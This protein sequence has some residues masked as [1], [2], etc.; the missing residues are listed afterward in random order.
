[1]DEKLVDIAFKQLA[2]LQAKGLKPREWI[3]GGDPWRRILADK[4]LSLDFSYVCIDPARPARAD[5]HIMGL[6]VVLTVEDHELMLV[7]QL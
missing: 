4:T 6:P 3:V 5:Y 1:M 2:S 7:P